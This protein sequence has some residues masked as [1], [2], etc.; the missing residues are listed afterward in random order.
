MANKKLIRNLIVGDVVSMHGG[1]FQIVAVPFDSI[2]HAPTDPA[3]GW[4]MGPSGVSVA[5][6]V[7]LSG[8][9]PG[10]FWPG[11]DWTF[12]GA[13]FVSVNVI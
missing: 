9:V 5:R 6:A 4:R 13:H 11:S 12:Q 2:G 8:N 3:T 7:C 1:K 10:Y